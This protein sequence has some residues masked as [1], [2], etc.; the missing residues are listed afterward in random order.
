LTKFIFV[1]Y[2]SVENFHKSKPEVFNYKKF[3]KS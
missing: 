2:C 1:H 3:I